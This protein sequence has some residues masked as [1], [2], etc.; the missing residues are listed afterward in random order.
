MS[1]DERRSRH[2]AL[3]R[4]ISENDLRAWGELF[5]AAMTKDPDLPRWHEHLGLQ[6]TLNPILA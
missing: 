6:P 2:Q 4:S 1:L 3:F 5:L